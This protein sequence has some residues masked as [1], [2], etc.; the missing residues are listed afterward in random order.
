MKDYKVSLS[1]LTGLEELYET[2]CYAQCI[3]EEFLDS[4][5]VEGVNTS[6]TLM[7]RNW[8]TLVVLKDEIDRIQYKYRKELVK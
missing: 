8:D 1:T 2:L 5:I 4:E 7:A 6:S 3:L